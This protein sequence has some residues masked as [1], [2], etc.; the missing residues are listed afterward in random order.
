LLVAALGHCCRLQLQ[1]A[2]E[3]GTQ[4]QSGPLLLLLQRQSTVVC[5]Y[6]LDS[7]KNPKQSK[8]R[9]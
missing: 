2:A 8:Q 3:P 6:L 1:P 9:L 7:F 4:Q 5:G